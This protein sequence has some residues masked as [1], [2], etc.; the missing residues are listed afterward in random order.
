MKKSKLKVK[1]HLNRY[2]R[3]I[4]HTYVFLMFAAILG[5]CTYFLLKQNKD[6]DVFTKKM[7]TIKKMKRIK[8][9]QVIQ[10]DMTQTCDSLYARINSFDPGVQASYEES[11]IKFL[12]NDLRHI[13]SQNS[14][15]RRLKLFEHIANFY[16]SWLIDKKELWSK[17][18]NIITFKK[19]LEECE[20]GI[21]KKTEIIKANFS[22]K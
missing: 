3:F 9:F 10:N 12:I 11:D 22:N 8:D 20:I 7:I 19:N 4:G 13:Y 18:Q 17:K 1:K 21:D 5:S 15:D 2:E 14:W 6:L 16:D